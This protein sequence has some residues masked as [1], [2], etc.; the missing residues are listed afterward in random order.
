MMKKSSLP[1]GSDRAAPVGR[2]RRLLSLPRRHPPA[3]HG[4]VPEADGIRDEAHNFTHQSDELMSFA[5]KREWTL[6]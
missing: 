4:H 2:W 5:M 6:P 3:R 1:R